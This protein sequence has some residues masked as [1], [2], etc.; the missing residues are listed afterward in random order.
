VLSVVPDTG[1]LVSGAINSQ[2][3]PYR[4]IKAWRDGELSLVVCPQLLDELRSV[5]ARPRLRRFISEEDAQ[6][7]VDALALAADV[8][9]NPEVIPGVVPD[10]PGDDYLV[11]LARETGADYLLASDQHLVGLESPR[12]P[13]IAP[14]DLLA[15]LERRRVEAHELGG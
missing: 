2:G 3:N 11:A 14:G 6:E 8:R 1:I 12:P 10:D 13:V 4:I 15:E 7:F 5:L 9:D